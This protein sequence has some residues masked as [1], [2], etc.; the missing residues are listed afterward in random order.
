ME[1]I[2]DLIR[3]SE[4][5]KHIELRP[6]LWRKLERRLDDDVPKAKGRPFWRPWMIAASIMMLVGFS[7]VWKSS[8]NYSLED[9]SAEKAP[10]FPKEELALFNVG[11]FRDSNTGEA[12][13]DNYPPADY[14]G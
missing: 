6:E 2:D 4:T 8:N 1:N 3:R 11:T 13:Y 9:L 5:E 14:N 12:Q 7:V 10:G